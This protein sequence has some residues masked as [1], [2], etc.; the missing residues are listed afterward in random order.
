MASEA[1]VLI[2]SSAGAEVEEGAT[3]LEGDALG[4]AGK[5]ELEGSEVWLGSA[6]GEPEFEGAEERVG[7]LVATALRVG[8]EVATALRVGDEVGEADDEPV[9]EAE[10]V[11]DGNMESWEPSC[12]NPMNTIV[13]PLTLLKLNSVTPSSAKLSTISQRL[14][15]GAVGLGILAGCF[16]LQKTFAR[17]AC[18][19]YS[20]N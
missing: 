13:A 7:E 17:P 4:G 15:A 11:G 16:V 9:A 14:P 2:A 3:E 12:C 1:A 6:E 20:P 5:T 18:G 10:P 19:A 8:D